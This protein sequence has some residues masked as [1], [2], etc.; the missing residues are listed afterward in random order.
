MAR[1]LLCSEASLRGEEKATELQMTDSTVRDALRRASGCGLALLPAHAGRPRVLVV[2]DDDDLRLLLHDELRR[3]G[4]DVVGCASGCGAVRQREW[5]HAMVGDLWSLDVVVTDLR[6]GEIDGLALLQRVAEA[7][8]DL[9]VVLISAFGDL[10]ART[11]AGA[12]GAAAFLDKPV[13]METLQR[14]VYQLARERQ[15]RVRR[16]AHAPRPRS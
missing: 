5:I 11:R 2:E 1:V 4:L 6:I 12:L 15:R 8:A 13:A 7:G 14:L 10:E 9:P 3:G 16:S